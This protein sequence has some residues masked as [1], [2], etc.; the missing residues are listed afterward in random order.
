MCHCV[1]KGIE[2]KEIDILGEYSSM[3]YFVWESAS[4][5]VFVLMGCWVF[6]SDTFKKFVA[7]SL[8]AWKANM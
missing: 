2:G 7:K 1:S 4:Q 5:I 3:Q 6:W 8:Q